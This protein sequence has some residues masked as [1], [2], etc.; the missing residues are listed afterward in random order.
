LGT[1]ISHG[2]V[3]F[4]KIASQGE[5]DGVIKYLGLTVNGTNMYEEQIIYSVD[6]TD[7]VSAQ[8]I[9]YTLS[10]SVHHVP[11]TYTSAHN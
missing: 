1:T 9:A 11:C 5:V 2:S 4:I 7:G 3:A 6:D 8:T 10:M